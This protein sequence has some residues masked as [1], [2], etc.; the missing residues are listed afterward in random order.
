MGDSDWAKINK[1]GSCQWK[2]IVKTV[3]SVPLL[4]MG[5]SSGLWYTVHHV[6]SNADIAQCLLI[7]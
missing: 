3:F 1:Y 5:L 4:I 6:D 2:C 7:L